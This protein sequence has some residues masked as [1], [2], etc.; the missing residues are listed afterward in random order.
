MI[1]NHDYGVEKIRDKCSVTLNKKYN[2]K[3]NNKDER[4]LDCD[5]S[6]LLMTPKSLALSLSPPRVPPFGT[7][8]RNLYHALL[9]NEKTITQPLSPCLRHQRYHVHKV[10][11]IAGN[12][13]Q[14]MPVVP[15][16]VASTHQLHPKLRTKILQQFQILRSRRNITY[17]PHPHL[18]ERT[19][20]AT[21][22]CI[23]SLWPVHQQNWVRDSGTFRFIVDALVA[24][25]GV[26]TLTLS[27]NPQTTILP[28][29]RLTQI[30]RTIPYGSHASQ[31][32]HL[33]QPQPE[34][35]HTTNRRLIIFIHGGAWGS[36]QPWMYR[37]I[38]APFIFSSSLPVPN[39][40][41][42]KCSFSV[43]VVGY[44]TYPDG[45]TA[46]EQVS[47]VTA[48]LNLLRTK[49]YSHLYTE[50]NITIIGHSSGAH[51]ALLMVVDH[52]IA[53]ASALRQRFDSNEQ[54]S[55]HERFLSVPTQFQLPFD[56][57]CGISGP[58]DISH[59]FDY[60]ASRGVE[61]LSPMKPV[62]GS[63]HQAFRLNSP[64]WRLRS[65]LLGLPSN[66]EAILNRLCPHIAL[67][68]GIEDDTVPF[69][70]TAEA[71]RMLR[72]FGITR[73]QEIYIPH[74]GHQDAIIQCMLGGK[75]RDEIMEWIRRILVSSSA[76]EMTGTRFTVQSRL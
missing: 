8:Q 53:Q 49:D 51:I 10:T 62:N 69:T 20:D 45:V 35:I 54:E 22:R 3:N 18:L 39:E 56:S 34:Q 30:C 70:A 12:G 5:K 63:T 47:D 52:I 75:A 31:F 71:G 17:Q 29:F 33:Y 58:Y 25:T 66:V 67:I 64:V 41:P 24:M 68:H 7:I 73:I 9:K 23:G 16:H 74:T 59:H 65:A 26:P 36:G 28:F 2:S 40:L 21:T 15:V 37:L 43:A 76:S 60:E 11:C 13:N 38:A 44:R 32:I 50:S 57:F 27:R 48:A 1:I 42:N 14:A 55:R 72:S 4:C 61:E 19:A 46:A 6:S